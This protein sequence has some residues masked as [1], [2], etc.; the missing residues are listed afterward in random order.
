MQ[1]RTSWLFPIMVLAA[2]AAIAFGALGIL[3]ITDR[4]PM[5]SFPANP[6]N[7]TS[8]ATQVIADTAHAA[9][10]DA[11]VAPAVHGAAQ[12]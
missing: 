5:V 8:A 4:A 3:A 1:S 10:G 11:G 2:A 12:K 7:T 6:L 9:Q